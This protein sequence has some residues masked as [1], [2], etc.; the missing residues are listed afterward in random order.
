MPSKKEEY[1]KVVEYENCERIQMPVL[2]YIF[3]VIS[4]FISL[5]LL[6]VAG[7]LILFFLIVDIFEDKPQNKIPSRKVYWVKK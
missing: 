3:A 6:I 7:V 4:H 5:T 2:L 1:V